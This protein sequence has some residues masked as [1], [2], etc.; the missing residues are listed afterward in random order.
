MQSSFIGSTV[1]HQRMKNLTAKANAI[2]QAP[3]TDTNSQASNEGAIGG[4]SGTTN[5]RVIDMS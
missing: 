2:S 5:N 1:T 4:D 3:N